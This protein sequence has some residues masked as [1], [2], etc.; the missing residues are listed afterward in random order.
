MMDD[1]EGGGDDGWVVGGWWPLLKRWE[2]MI[3]GR[4]RD[5]R[6]VDFV[7][8]EFQSLAFFSFIT[9]LLP[10]GPWPLPFPPFPSFLRHSSYSCA[11]LFD[12]SLI[13]H[14]N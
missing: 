9:S 14:R 4:V 1:E 3:G 11:D 2:L 13:A 10:I 5:R 7:L 6:E 8:D 12:H